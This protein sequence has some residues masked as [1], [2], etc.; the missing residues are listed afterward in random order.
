MSCKVCQGSQLFPGLLIR[1]NLIPA[2]IKVKQHLFD[3]FLLASVLSANTS[4]SAW[5][6]LIQLFSTLTWC[7]EEESLGPDR[8]ISIIISAFYAFRCWKVAMR[9]PWSLLQA[10]HPQ[11]VCTADVLQPLSILM[12]SSRLHILSWTPFQYHP[13]Q[14][15][16]P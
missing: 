10:E 11:P 16:F 14:D 7:F 3:P 5:L 15:R 2:G 1:I 12:A 6:W 9:S 4:V 13:N 8:K